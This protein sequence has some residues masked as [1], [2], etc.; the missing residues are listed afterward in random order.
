MLDL[1]KDYRIFRNIEAKCGWVAS[2]IREHQSYYKE[3]PY[4]K[5]LD[6][7]S[8]NRKFRG[9]NMKHLVKINNNLTDMQFSAVFISNAMLAACVES[10]FDE[11]GNM[12][13]FWVLDD[14]GS[15]I[16]IFL[17]SIDCKDSNFV[18]SLRDGRKF[19]SLSTKPCE[20]SSDYIFNQYFD[21]DFSTNY[22]EWTQE[23]L[24]MLKLI[25]E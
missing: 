12:S 8:H 19:I 14:P 11:Y 22:F 10:E 2:D 20:D 6:V 5:Q 25:I 23:Q 7:S 4:R 24:M 9:L 18:F 3:L 17:S 16:K 13:K 1:K 15:S 21:V